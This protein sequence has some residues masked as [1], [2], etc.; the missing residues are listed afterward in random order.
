MPLSWQLPLYFLSPPSLHSHT[1]SCQKSH[2]LAGP[3]HRF[4]GGG[5]K[6]TFEGFKLYQAQWDAVNSNIN[7]EVYIK[8]CTWILLGRK[9]ICDELRRSHERRGPPFPDNGLAPALPCWMELALRSLAGLTSQEKVYAVFRLCSLTEFLT[10]F[11]RGAGTSRRSPTQ[12]SYFILR[13]LGRPDAWDQRRRCDGVDGRPRMTEGLF[14]Y[15]FGSRT[16]IY[17]RRILL[18]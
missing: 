9:V 11:E 3:N 13:Q 15:L 16:A 18:K 5:R 1:H 12:R 4:R 6:F 17:S 14:M 7:S 2:G 8:C 10:A